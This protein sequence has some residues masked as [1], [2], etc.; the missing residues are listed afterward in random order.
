MMKKR[1]WTQLPGFVPPILAGLHSQRILQMVVNLNF[2]VLLPY[3]T[4]DS[5]QGSNA[6]HAWP[7]D[8]ESDCN[9]EYH[10]DGMQGYLGP[11]IKI[12]GFY[13]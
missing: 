13:W 3:Q 11:K 6:G 12:P 8:L 10:S 1:H 4:Q 7:L 5:G 9:V 2:L